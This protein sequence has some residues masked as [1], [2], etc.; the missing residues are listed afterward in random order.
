MSVRNTTDKKAQVHIGHCWR[1]NDEIIFNLLLW[2]PSHGKRSRGRP[3]YTIVYGYTYV[4][5]LIEDTGLDKQGLKD[6]MDDR[7]KFIKIGIDKKKH[8]CHVDAQA[9]ASGDGET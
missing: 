7:A 4:D 8:L 6:A 3:C 1:R 9:A 2:E 5:Q